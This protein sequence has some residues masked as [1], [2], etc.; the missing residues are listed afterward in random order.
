MNPFLHASAD[1]L[2]LNP[3]LFAS[4]PLGK[5]ATP[6]QSQRTVSLDRPALPQR[7]RATRAQ[8]GAQV[9]VTLNAVVGCQSDDDNAVA[10]MKPLRDAIAAEMG[11]D[12]ADRRIRWQYG[13]TE[14]RGAEGVLVIVE[15]VDGLAR[16]NGGERQNS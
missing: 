14:T 10:A 2:R 1:F 4:H 12:D 13:Q 6:A 5:L 8:T 15:T 16:A 7:R 9:I 11:A 3:G